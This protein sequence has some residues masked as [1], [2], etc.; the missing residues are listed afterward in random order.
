MIYSAYL[1]GFVYPVVCH[2]IWDSN[3]FLY[4]KVMDFS[5]SGAGTYI[6][7]RGVVDRRALF[8]VFFLTQTA[9]VHLVG[10][11]AAMAGSVALGPR[12]GRF[13]RNETTGKM[14]P[15]EIPGHNA[16]LSALGTLLLWFGEYKS[17]I[18]G[19]AESHEI[20]MH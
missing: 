15:V 5:G 10:G 2:W 18:L 4:G 9:A 19:I 6:L 13:V 17:S 11:A 8:V 3:G 1:S 7:T 16:V 20:P 14:E 12:I